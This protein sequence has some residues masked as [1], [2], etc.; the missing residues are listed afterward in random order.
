MNRVTKKCA[1][2]DGTFPSH[3]AVGLATPGD[4]MPT[5]PSLKII[6]TMF[7]TVPVRL[8]TPLLRLHFTPL[9]PARGAACCPC[10]SGV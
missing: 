8:D 1:D 3:A 6:V 4:V 5:M 7:L 9:Q 2:D 10:L